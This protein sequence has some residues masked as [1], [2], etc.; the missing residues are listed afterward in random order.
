MRLALWAGVTENVYPIGLRSHCGH[1]Q[2][3]EDAQNQSLMRLFLL[4]LYI[5]F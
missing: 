1:G 3:Q 2:V 4:Y 5:L